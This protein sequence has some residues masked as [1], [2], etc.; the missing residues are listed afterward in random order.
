ML[1]S[2]ALDFPGA[3][4]HLGWL[5]STLP[6]WD[7]GGEALAPDDLGALE[8]FVKG[9]PATALCELLT[10]SELAALGRRVSWL[11]RHGAL[12]ELTDDGG[13]PPYP[14]PLV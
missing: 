7:F 5:C 9:G 4:V 8:R 3:R 13:W 2:F 10:P 12:P 6:I 14:W 11:L 1:G